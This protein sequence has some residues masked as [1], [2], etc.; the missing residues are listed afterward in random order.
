LGKVSEIFIYADMIA[1]LIIGILVLK[2]AYN[3]LKENFSSL[4]GKQVTD[5]DYINELK[6]I[7]NEELEVKGIDTLII[8]EY[9]PIYQVN[10]EVLMDGN[11]ILKDAHDVLDRLEENLKN[12]DVKIQH[13]IIHVSPYKC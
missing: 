9:G 12:Y 1:M 13:I 6:K 7:I 4:L 10:L 2:I 8:L 11:I 5:E 3:I